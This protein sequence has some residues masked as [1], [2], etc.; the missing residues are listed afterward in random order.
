MIN[1]NVNRWQSVRLLF[2]KHVIGANLKSNY[3]CQESVRLVEKR[4]RIPFLLRDGA[5]LIEVGCRASVTL[6]AG[7]DSNSVRPVAPRQ[8]EEIK[9]SFENVREMIFAVG[10]RSQSA[11]AV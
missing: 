6:T 1:T 7:E 10:V 11:T 2:D 3:E 5:F 4:G 8:T 9:F